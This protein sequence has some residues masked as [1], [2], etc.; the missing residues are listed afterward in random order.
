MNR[1]VYR[2][3][4]HQKGRFVIDLLQMMWYNKAEARA[5]ARAA[6]LTLVLQTPSAAL[7]TASQK[8]P[9]KQ[10]FLLHAIISTIITTKGE[11]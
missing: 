6:E 1:K 11:Y 2:K 10:A 7:L 8:R 4:Q 5:H 9:C 3:L